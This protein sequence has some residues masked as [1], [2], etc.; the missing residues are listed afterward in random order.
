MA[1]LPFAIAKP[2]AP[3]NL[4]ALAH[5]PV[6]GQV[7]TN[8]PQMGQDIVNYLS[9]HRFSFPNKPTFS[10]VPQGQV[11]DGLRSGVSGAD[12]GYATYP[13]GRIQ[14]G[15]TYANMGVNGQTAEEMLHEALHAATGGGYPQDPTPQQEAGTEQ[16]VESEAQDIYPGLAHYLG[17]KPNSG[18][19][20]SYAPL[21]KQERI[22]SAK[23]TGTPWTS[24]Q[25]RAWRANYYFTDPAKRWLAAN[26]PS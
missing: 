22:A 14:I 19:T 10:V 2:E 13:D 25:A 4:R 20:M 9:A 15:Q 26:P 3:L 21:V 5:M 17:I 24:P 8:L 6:L 18:Y 1:G 12:P 23:A 7:P 11:A 16:A